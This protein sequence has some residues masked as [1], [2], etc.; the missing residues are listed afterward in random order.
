MDGRT[1]RAS[2]HESGQSLTD[3]IVSLS[4]GKEVDCGFK[5]ALCYEAIV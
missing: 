1:S 4:A 2:S 5:V 3:R